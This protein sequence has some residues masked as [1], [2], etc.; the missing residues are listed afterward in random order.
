MTTARLDSP[1]RAAPLLR[2]AGQPVGLQGPGTPILA[3][4]VSIMITASPLGEEEAVPED[5][6]RGAV[7]GP[8]P[9]VT[10]G[11]GSWGVVMFFP[12]EN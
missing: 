10:R 5:E 4:R 7:A 9:E 2:P 6:E 8:V 1:G 3:R 12:D 11:R